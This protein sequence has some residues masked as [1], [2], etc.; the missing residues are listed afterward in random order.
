MGNPMNQ[1]RALLP[2]L[3]LLSACSGAAGFNEGKAKALIRESLTTDCGQYFELTDVKIID[4][5]I[6]GDSATVNAEGIFKPTSAFLR[7]DLSMQG[8]EEA[9][10]C[11][12]GSGGQYQ[13]G[14][15]PE[16]PSGGLHA[17]RTYQFQRWE[18][19]WRLVG[20]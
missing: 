17:Q 7:K 10:G 15:P 11:F 13:F 16:I 14:R 3:A 6:A 8:S 12:M 1:L 5:Q 9:L 2:V 20:G 4:K 19:G 18:K